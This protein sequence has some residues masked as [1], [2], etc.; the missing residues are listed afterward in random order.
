MSEGLIKFDLTNEEI[1]SLQLK[2][3]D[4]QLAQ[5]AFSL[6]LYAIAERCG[7]LAR[8]AKISMD[9]KGR[10]VILAVPVFTKNETKENIA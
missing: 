5:Q 4:M 6:E 1:F 9:D 8:D 3:R 10:T 7:F 2:Q